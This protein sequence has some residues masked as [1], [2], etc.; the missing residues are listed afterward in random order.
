MKRNIYKLIITTLVFA[1]AFHASA[2][3]IITTFAGDGYLGGTLYGYGGY[4]GDGGPAIHAE[5]KFPQD[6]TT[7]V[8]GNVY[9]ADFKNNVVRKVNTAGIISTIAG[10]DSSGY[11]GDGGAATNARL[12]LP[13]AVKADAA[14]NVYIADYGNNVVRKVTPGGIITTVAGNGAFDYTGDGGPATAAAISSP[15]GLAIDATGNLFVS[16]PNFCVVRKI[17]PAGAITTSVGNATAYGSY[18]GD[19]GPATAAQMEGPALMTF[20][21]A[22][23]LY[24]SDTWAGVVR[25]VDPSNIITTFAGNGLGGYTGD[26]GPATAA[27]LTPGGLAADDSGSILLADYFNNVVRKI[28]ASGIITTIAGNGYGAGLNIGAYTGDGGLA[29]NAEFFDPASVTISASGKIYIVDSRNDVVRTLSKNRAP[30]FVGSVSSVTVC[31]NAAVSVNALLSIVDSDVQQTER[32]SVSAPP[33]HGSLTGFSTSQMA[34]GGLTNPLDY[35]SYTPAIGYSGLDAF[36]VQI[37]DGVDSVNAAISV[38]IEPLPIAGAITGPDSV[39]PGAVIALSDIATGGIWTSSNSTTGISGAGE[40]IGI[41][42]GT[43][44]ISYTVVNGC[45]A[46]SAV[47]T[48]TVLSPGACTTGLTSVIAKNV[49]LNVYPNPNSGEFSVNLIS[50]ADEQVHIFITTVVGE[51]IS[52]FATSTNK[53]NTVK[54]NAAAGIYFVSASTTQGRYVTKIVVN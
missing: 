15:S 10:S 1:T 21:H 49:G 4:T 53:E 39:C 9:I 3:T 36:A 20:D 34:T 42:A 7:D 24:I 12:Y 43:D 31:E 25:K 44:I 16:D 37:S 45:G 23:N 27:A 47:H 2:Q 51:T 50:G 17:T 13:I 22:G 38:L 35:L 52:S 26:G 30:F 48:I 14:G 19:G 8:A 32:W 11:S 29:K 5:L 40:V 46:V 18:S 6:V 33:T 41:S 54:F 28:N